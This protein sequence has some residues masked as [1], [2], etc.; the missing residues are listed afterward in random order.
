MSAPV[1]ARVSHFGGASSGAAVVYF[2]VFGCLGISPGGLWLLPVLYGALAVDF[3]SES[4][5]NW[6][7]VFV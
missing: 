7:L 1:T 2:S 5:P 6:R 4:I 3:F